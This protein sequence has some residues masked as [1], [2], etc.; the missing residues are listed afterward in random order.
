MK[1]KSISTNQWTVTPDKAGALR[2]GKTFP[3]WTVEAFARIVGYSA[4]QIRYFVGELGMPHHGSRHR[5]RT[6]L[7]LGESARRWLDEIY[8]PQAGRHG[9]YHRFNAMYAGAGTLDEVENDRLDEAQAYARL[10]GEPIPHDEYI[11]D[12]PDVQKEWK[13]F[14]AIKLAGAM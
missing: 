10:Y 4:R 2:D 7:R 3:F 5:G 13:R 11:E 6:T 14:R 1:A 8:R 12:D 9:R